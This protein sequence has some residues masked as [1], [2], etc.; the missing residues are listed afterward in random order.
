MYYRSQKLS[1]VE[2]RLFLVFS[3]PR[4]LQA[5]IA[6]GTI[7]LY[8]DPHHHI[9]MPS[10]LQQIL[11][12]LSIP[13][14]L[15]FYRA[16]ACPAQLFLLKFATASAHLSA[17]IQSTPLLSGLGC[18]SGQPLARLQLIPIRK[19]LQS[20]PVLSFNRTALNIFLRSK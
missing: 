8:S 13:S 5:T 9:P 15:I 4:L 16:Q 3:G 17:S 7:L 14:L 18:C 6:S 1:K 10:K 11:Q 20:V 19:A 12:S 2:A